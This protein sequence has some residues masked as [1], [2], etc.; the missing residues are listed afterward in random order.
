MS[1]SG[2]FNLIAPDIPAKTKGK[3]PAPFSLRLTAEE[4]ARL[5][6]EA[7]G[8]PL[9]GYIKAKLLGTAP[10]RTRRSGLPVEDRKALAQALGI[11]GQSRLANNL[12]QL[13]YAANIGVLPLD[14]DTEADLHAALCDV[15]EVRRLLLVALG[16]KPEAAPSPFANATE[17]A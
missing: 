10:L 15:R 7:R 14:L 3:R 16:L 9:G 6:A 13:A 2:T 1:I 5:V 8:A 11:L 4:R 12:N 17:E